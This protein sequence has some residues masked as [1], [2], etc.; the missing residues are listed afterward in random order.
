MYFPKPSS[1]GNGNLN[2]LLN[3]LSE[4]DPNAINVNYDQQQQQQHSILDTDTYK[5]ML[6]QNNNQSVDS[7]L[8]HNY[9]LPAPTLSYPVANSNN[10]NNTAAVTQI[11]P[12]IQQAYY[13]FVQ[14][15][16]QYRKVRPEPVNEK[17]IVG[18][19]V[20]FFQD[21]V[22]GGAAELTK[23]HHH[24]NHHHNQRMQTANSANST[25][26]LANE[27]K[28]QIE[29]LHFENVAQLDS[30]RNNTGIADIG[31]T[32]KPASF[33]DAN[34]ILVVGYKTGFSVWIIDVGFIIF[35]FNRHLS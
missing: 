13:Q 29:W 1:S 28:E 25:I 31:S 14:P 32:S 27:I 3:P 21:V 12:P 24:P 33:N 22:V 23:H 18:S 8:M 4:L 16:Q 19:V 9:S 2:N 34:I 26:S 15:R 11:N 5:S 7:L 6:S 35:V 17:T 10:N 30:S 20:G